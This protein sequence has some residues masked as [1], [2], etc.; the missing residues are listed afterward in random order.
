M[1][2]YRGI[3]TEMRGQYWSPGLHSPVSRFSE[4]PPVDSGPS[5]LWIWHSVTT[6][7]DCHEGRRI[8]VKY[9][10]FLGGKIWY[11]KAIFSF[12]LEVHHVFSCYGCVSFMM[13]SVF[14]LSYFIRR[15][16]LVSQWL[17]TAGLSL[18]TERHSLA[19]DHCRLQTVA[20]IFSKVWPK[21]V[22]SEKGN[23]P[24]K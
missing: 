20:G 10:C 2:L 24:G 5:L 17:Q 18:Q 23:T 11:F 14:L 7:S 4:C 15:R 9:L 22:F 13:I 8:T 16:H 1:Q 3:I 21:N 19:S 12:D 6:L